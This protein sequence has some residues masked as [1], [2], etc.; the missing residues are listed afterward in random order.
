[1]YF[2]KK[3]DMD[4]IALNTPV[5]GTSAQI[6]KLAG[7]Y[8]FNYLI[9]HNLVFKVLIPNCVH[10]EYLVEAP[11][12][13]AEEVSLALQNSMEKAG[14][15]FTSVVTLKAIPEISTYWKH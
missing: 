5:Q 7:I 2:S 8:F 12:E 13:L 11:K 15:V 3:G 9:Q 14:K 10:D 1:M 4:R 6:T